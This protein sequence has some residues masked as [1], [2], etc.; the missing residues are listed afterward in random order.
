MN[1]GRWGV[2]VYSHSSLKRKFPRGH[3]W[4]CRNHLCAQSSLLLTNYPAPPSH[5]TPTSQLWPS[6]CSTCK[7]FHFSLFVRGIKLE[8]VPESS[9]VLPHRRCS[10]G[11]KN[12]VNQEKQDLYTTGNI[13]EIKSHQDLWANEAKEHK[14]R[15]SMESVH[16][17]GLLVDCIYK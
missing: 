3:Y 2:V 10:H 15:C 4:K 6:S 1:G 8:R 16:Q 5:P 7:D 14:H 11:G 13:W 17:L 9:C 12:K